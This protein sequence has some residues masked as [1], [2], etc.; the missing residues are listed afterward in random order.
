LTILLLYLL[1]ISTPQWEYHQGPS[2]YL[3][4]FSSKP[5]RSL[6]PEF[7][8]QN[9]CWYRQKSHLTQRVGLSL[10]PLNNLSKYSLHL[11]MISSSFISSR[12]VPSLMHL[13]WLMSL[14]FRSRI[15]AIL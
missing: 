14:V 8:S 5:P 11:S 7:S 13:I 10:S 12:S 4:S 9:V 1:G 2:L 6:P 3:S 15:L